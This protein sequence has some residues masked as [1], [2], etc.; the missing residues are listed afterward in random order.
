MI[1]YVAVGKRL[2]DAR[3]R[4]T[5]AK[6]AESRAKAIATAA[7]AEIEECLEELES[8]EASRPLLDAIERRSEADEHQ[9]GPTTRPPKKSSGGRTVTIGASAERPD[10]KVRP[11]GD[12]AETI[13]RMARERGN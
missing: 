6:D 13:E 1:D 3:R 11:R 5:A 8:G 10:R 2:A 4:Q 7:A 12:D 9:R